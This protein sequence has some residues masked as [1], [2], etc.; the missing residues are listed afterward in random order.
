MPRA[1]PL[2]R[3]QSPEHNATAAHCFLRHP[4]DDSVG[5]AE[6]DAPLWADRLSTTGHRFLAAGWQSGGCLRPHH[7]GRSPPNLLE[8]LQLGRG[9][10]EMADL[11]NESQEL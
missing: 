7:M 10:A 11:P 3:R 5:R 8:G 1:G 4:A 2:A 9:P 6:G